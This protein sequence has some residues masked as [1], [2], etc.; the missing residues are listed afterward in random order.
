MANCLIWGTPAEYAEDDGEIIRVNSSRAGGKYRV[1]GTN[2]SKVSS[3]SVD[4]KKR[5]T[6]WLLYQRR[7]G[8]AIPKVSS[9]TLEEIEHR[10]LMS[11]V[12]KV[13][14]VLMFFG[15]QIKKIGGNVVI[16]PAPESPWATLAAETESEDLDELTCLLQ[17]MVEQRLLT[18]SS[19]HTHFSPAP[20]GWERIDSLLRRGSDSSQVFIAMW[21]NEVTGE[22]YSTGIV[23]ALNATGYKPVRIDK[24]EHNNKI[25]DEI[26][27]EIRRSRF[28]VADFTCEPKNVRGGVYYEAGFAQGLGLP[29]IWT[30]KESSLNDLH[31]DTRQYSHIVWKTPADLFTQL[32]NRIGATIGDGPLPKSNLQ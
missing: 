21:F 22:A 18:L 3:L 4:Q 17:L 1:T 6:T 11:F 12:D 19:N 7:A 31:F 29:V 5:L 8:I 27:A 23:P 20:A 13:D 16:T 9:Y 24:K 32:K 26:M 30:C 10:P 14:A 2:L 28:V 15:R 25:D